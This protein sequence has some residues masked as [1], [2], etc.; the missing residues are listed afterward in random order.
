MKRSLLCISLSMAMMTSLLTGCGQAQ[1]NPWDVPYEIDGMSTTP[2]KIFEGIIEDFSYSKYVKIDGYYSFSESTREDAS[3]YSLTFANRYEDISGSFEFERFFEDRENRLAIYSGEFTRKNSSAY[4][5]PSAVGDGNKSVEKSATVSLYKDMKDGNDSE[6]YYYDGDEDAAVIFDLESLLPESLEGIDVMYEPQTE[7]DPSLVDITLSGDIDFFSDVYVKNCRI[8][9]GADTIIYTY[10]LN[11]KKLE[12][13]KVIGSGSWDNEGAVSHN[14]HST[15]VSLVFN[16]VEMSNAD[17]E[18]PE[19]PEVY[20]ENIVV[21]SVI[22]G[23]AQIEL[24]DV[25][26]CPVATGSGFG[27]QAD[28]MWTELLNV[29]EEDRDTVSKFTEKIGEI[30]KAHQYEEVTY[31]YSLIGEKRGIIKI[32][33]D[34]DSDSG[35]IMIPF[36]CQK[37][38][39]LW[40]NPVKVSSD[41]RTE[42]GNKGSVSFSYIDDAGKVY[43]YK[44]KMDENAQLVLGYSSEREKLSQ[45]K[46]ES[47]LS[48][49]PEKDQAELKK[50]VSDCTNAAFYDITKYEVGSEQAT[51]YVLTD[52]AD[53]TN[54][55]VVDGEY[56]INII[57]EK[58]IK[59]KLPKQDKNEN[60][61]SWESLPMYED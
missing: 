35:Y 45:L 56:K 34:G 50:L 44:Y 38:E 2:R 22:V 29:P 15:S 59:D 51:Y 57:S 19:L 42:V 4:A 53:T 7:T 48:M 27:H 23:V 18:R 43:L 28:A 54:T 61:V 39:T 24:S 5:I 41:V 60:E 10:D 14:Y 11:E 40:G 13:I 47:V 21:N 26:E 3:G 52:T 55:V 49:Y 46:D 33:F 6:I 37:D 36:S 58:E 30:G 1:V 32:S 9:H 16:I 12:S 8:G 17:K 20:S 31:N 25:L